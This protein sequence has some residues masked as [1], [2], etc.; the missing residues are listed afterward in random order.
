MAKIV[1]KETST[2]EYGDYQ[3]Q[4]DT[5]GD[6][7]VSEYNRIHGFWNCKMILTKKELAAALKLL[8]FIVK[9]RNL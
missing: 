3:I 1:K 7:V 8:E 9:D 5:D 2:Y 4:V 6:F